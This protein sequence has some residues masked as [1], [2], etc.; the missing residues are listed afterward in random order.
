[1]EQKNLTMS[2]SIPGQEIIDLVETL[3]LMH[4]RNRSQQVVYLIKEAAK[5]EKLLNPQHQPATAEK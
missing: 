1:M 2:V 3:A 4:G 5:K